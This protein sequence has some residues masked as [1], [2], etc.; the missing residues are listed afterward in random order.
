MGFKEYTQAIV[1]IK[2]C[3]PDNNEIL[4]IIESCNLEPIQNSWRMWTDNR[5]YNLI[6]KNDKTAIIR[7]SS[8]SQIVIKDIY[9]KSLPKQ[10]ADNSKWSMISLT[11]SENVFV[12]FWGKDD[13]L[14]LSC[15][16][17][18]KWENKPPLS[19]GINTLRSIVRNLDVETYNS[20]KGISWPEE[21]IVKTLISKW[22]P[23]TNMKLDMLMTN[24]EIGQKILTDAG[25]MDA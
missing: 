3:Y 6:I 5:G 19:S 13:K 22:P 14:R 20:I 18:G 16:M 8:N 12:W 4:N 9:L 2:A 23:H 1:S 21:N 7:Q 15:Y 11:E 24:K 10:I 25:A 17:N